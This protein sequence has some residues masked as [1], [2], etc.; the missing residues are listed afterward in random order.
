MTL[1]FLTLTLALALKLPSLAQQT[2]VSQMERLD[3]GVAAVRNTSGTG[4]FVS[5][6]FLGTDD[7]EATSFDLLR[8]GSRIAKDLYVTNANDASGNDN[9]LYQVVTK[10]NGIPVDTTK[11]V[12]AWGESYLAVALDR[13]ATGEQGGTY[14]PNDCSVGDVDGDGEY[15]I[16]VKWYPSNAKDNS[17][18][19]ITDN[20]LIDCYKLDGTKLWR[21]DLGRNI[22]SGAHYTQFLVYDFDGD[23]RAEMMCKTGPGSI[24]GKGHYVNQAA[25]DEAIKAVSGTALYRSSGGRI[26]GGQ[27]WLTVFSGQTGEAMHTIFYNPNRNM[28][29][30]GEADGS[31]NWGVG[32]KNDTGSYGNRGERFLAAVACL[33]G[34]GQNPSA[35]F[36]RGYYDYAFIWAVDFDGKQLRQRWLS[37][38]KTQNSYSVTTYDANGKA[39]TRNYTNMKPTSGSGSGTMYQNGN[40]NLSVADVDG[41]GCDEIVWGSACCDHDGRV[42]YGTGYGHGDAIHLAD[43]C[44]DRPGLEVFQIHEGGSYGWDLHDAA[45]G[46]ILYSATGGGDNGRGMAGNF[47]SKVRGSLFWSANDGSPRSAVTGATVYANGGSQNFRVYWDGDLQDELLDGSK[48]DNWNDGAGGTSRLVT[49]Y[50]IGPAATCNGSKNTPNLQA[51]ILGDWRE[52]IILH[53]DVSTLAIY[54]SNIATP[55]RMPTLMHDHV[56]RMGIAWQNTAYNQPPHLGYYLPDAMMPKFLNE[57]YR[58]IEAVVGDSVVFESK[59]RYAKTVLLVNSFSPDGSKKFYAPPEG[60]E[61]P[62][63]DKDTKVLTLKGVAEMEG[64]YRLAYKLTGYGGEVVNDTIVV[65]V[66]PSVSGISETVCSSGIGD[67]QRIAV[68]DAAGRRMPQ[69]S[70]D[71]LPRGLYMIRDGGRVKKVMNWNK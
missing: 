37:S 66:G 50:N 53:D 68:Y 51:D 49:F 8:N 45:T 18:S 6:R 36:C 70:L 22:R 65:S 46:Q 15:E 67:G 71:G 17:Q 38:N 26:T 3:R 27:E 21:I 69:Q 11:T 32:G 63:F 43:H 61:R 52:E 57:D 9:S 42:L 1:I 47:D 39:S 44:P 29:Y 55:Y 28:T 48:L 30:G 5:W 40:H 23:G 24:D 56:Y 20:T 64:E 35:V 2:P 14:A 12:K 25:T 16:I 41:D 13:P 33:G 19:G 58:H 60:F 31:V 10:V 4:N 34:T 7:E 59:M 54:T 62:V